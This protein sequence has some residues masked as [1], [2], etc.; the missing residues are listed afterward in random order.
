MTNHPTTRT[1]PLRLRPHQLEPGDHVVGFADFGPVAAVRY[2]GA[3][4][5]GTR[6][7]E[8]VWHD[9]GDLYEITWADRPDPMVIRGKHTFTV[10]RP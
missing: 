1:E 8:A 7:Q 9:F 3:G 5:D 4:S 2:A 10:V 6:H